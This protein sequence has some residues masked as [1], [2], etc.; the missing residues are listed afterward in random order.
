M[1]KRISE[2]EEVFPLVEMLMVYGHEFDQAEDILKRIYDLRTNKKDVQPSL[3]VM[4]DVVKEWLPPFFDRK[5]K[6]FR[7]RGHRWWQWHL[8]HV[9]EERMADTVGIEL[10]ML[11]VYYVAYARALDSFVN[12]GQNPAGTEK[13]RYLMARSKL[14]GH[15]VKR[16]KWNWLKWKWDNAEYDAH[17]C[18]VLGE[19]LSRRCKEGLLMWL[20]R[21]YE[22]SNEAFMDMCKSLDSGDGEVLFNNGEGW[23]SVLFDLAKEGVFGDLDKVSNV[24]VH[25]ILVYLQ[26]NKVKADSLARKYDK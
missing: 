22:A 23:T 25:T 10:S 5:I 14:L 9:R 19:V 6:W 11:N 21:Y 13:E 8:I 24:P 2:I 16:K 20:I 4:L 18:N 15:I 17:S 12:A 26:M 7:L 1:V 3:D